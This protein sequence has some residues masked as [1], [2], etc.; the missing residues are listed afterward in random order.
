MS[1]ERFQRIKNLFVAALQQEPQMRAAFLDEACGVSAFFGD[2]NRDGLMDLFLFQAEGFTLFHNR[3]V[4]RF[5]DSTESLGL[6]P[7]LAVRNVQLGDYDGDGFEDMVIQT[8]E[9]DKILRNQNGRGFNEVILP[10]VQ[11]QGAGTDGPITGPDK[12]LGTQTG[13]CL[14]DLIPPGSEAAISFDIRYVNDNSP[15]SVG[16]GVPE[17]EGG[18]DQTTL[19]DIV[20]GTL[21]GEDLGIPFE[22]EDDL[23]GSVFDCINAH[24]TKAGTA[25]RAESM[26]P[27][28]RGIHGIGDYGVYGESSD[29]TGVYGYASAVT[30]ETC[31]VHGVNFSAEGYGV[32]GEGP[33]YGVFGQA[34][35]TTGW[36]WGVRGSSESTKGHGVAGYAT[37]ATGNTFG[38]LGRSD[39]EEGKGV[40]GYAAAGT[41]ENF[42]VLGQTNSPDGFGLY[43]EAKATTGYATGIFGTSAAYNGKGIHG[44]STTTSGTSYGVYGESNAPTGVGV[45]GGSPGIGVK[46]SATDTGGIGVTGTCFKSGGYGMKAQGYKY[47]LY[48][49]GGSVSTSYGVYAFSNSSDGYGVFAEAPKYG[50]RGHSTGAS[51]IAHGVHGVC[52]STSG[53]GVYAVATAT[54]GV[55]YGVYAQ[56]YS[57]LG[58]GIYAWNS[59]TSGAAYGIYGKS[60][61][62]AGHGGKFQGGLYGV[63]ATATQSGGIGVYGSATGGYGGYFVGG[64]STDTLTIRGG[65]DLSERFDV[66]RGKAQTEPE[67]GM[68]V[69][70][71]PQKPGNLVIS[72]KAYD[73]TVAGIISG[74]GGIRIGM[75]MGQENSEAD[76]EVPVAL[77]GRVYCLADASKNPIEPG[78][79]LTTSDR[80][81]HAMKVSDPLRAHGAIIGKAMTPLKAG[82][83]LVLVLVTLH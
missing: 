74:A 78:D 42:G 2:Y 35:A 48:A 52:D 34:T 38:V 7:G 49:S 30:G 70:I 24:T 40:Y 36:N 80:V 65:S 25:I 27:S 77:T 10:E 56:D 31:G 19:N 41:G 53:R 67:P 57:S 4:L 68:V 66:R 81:G 44:E 72:T 22:L 11:R 26:G 16:L 59:A 17:V 23:D 37:S 51:G 54:S 79:L 60:S 76:G 61:S 28:G 29:H 20:D 6:D 13:P 73:R 12:K 33:E 3:G 1:A 21:A 58:Y 46:G 75:L 82:R 32:L 55:T 45:F 71:D 83:G 69:C 47:G 39:S 14:P 15:G 62:P 50:V 64:A 8:P 9:G 5:R 18:N 43:G 63:H